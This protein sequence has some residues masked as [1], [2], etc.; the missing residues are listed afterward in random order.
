MQGIEGA[1]IGMTGRL[2]VVVEVYAIGHPAHVDDPGLVE[3]GISPT[4]S[5]DLPVAPPEQSPQQ[6]SRQD[7]T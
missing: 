3:P 4:P 5:G 2:V 7:Q 1:F 6:D